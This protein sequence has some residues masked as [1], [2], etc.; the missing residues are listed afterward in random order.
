MKPIEIFY[1][2]SHKDGEL[3]DELEKHLAILKRGGEI[4]NWHDR[5]IT[6]GR[7]WEGQI[8]SHL[9]SAHI[10]FLLVSSDFLAS[11]Y[12]YDVEVRTAMAR[13]DAAAARVVPIILRACDWASAPF[14][15]LLA[16]PKDGRPVTSWSNRD[17][18]FWDVAKGIRSIIAE[19]SDNRTTPAEFIQVPIDILLDKQASVKQEDL[20]FL[21]FLVEMDIAAGD[22]AIVLQA[23]TTVTHE[24]SVKMCEGAEEFQV[25]AKEAKAHRM[26]AVANVIATNLKG[27]AK[28]L[29][30]ICTRFH[31]AS[32]K[33]AMSTAKFL[34]SAKVKTPEDLAALDQFEEI[35]R[36]CQTAIIEVAVSLA[37]VRESMLKIHGASGDLN[38]AVKYTMSAMDRLGHEYNLLESNLN[39]FLTMMGRMREGFI[40]SE[41]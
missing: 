20:G 41:R 39:G 40:S 22:L 19:L 9:N 10:I 26:L 21:D 35:T 34:T 1:S 24:I 27:Y 18:A 14:A 37:G 4:A 3:R 23:F 17:E 33:L 11:D 30:D 5:R 16:L 13:N 6:G 36:K 8:D 31:N 7:E 25:V 38:K 12:C 32:V 15:R 29:D 28:Q 2:Y